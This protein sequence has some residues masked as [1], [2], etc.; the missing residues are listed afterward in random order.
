MAA[1]DSYLYKEPDTVIAN[2]RYLEIAEAVMG[3][4]KLEGLG[5]MPVE[6]TE[7]ALSSSVV[8]ALPWSL[9]F[10]IPKFEAQT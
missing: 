5:V 6:Y 9:F 2:E 7:D 10:E 4:V 1:S 3:I 8:H